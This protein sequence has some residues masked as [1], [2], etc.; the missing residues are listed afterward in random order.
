[1]KNFDS[2]WITAILLIKQGKYVEADLIAEQVIEF[3]KKGQGDRDV[4]KF[5]Y[6]LGREYYNATRYEKALKTTMRASEMDAVVHGIES[7]V[8]ASDMCLLAMIHEKL[9]HFSDAEPYYLRSLE[10]RQ[11]AFGD[12]HPETARTLYQIGCFY[13]NNLRLDKSR[14]FFQKAYAI[15]EKDDQ[16]DATLYLEL[17]SQL[18]ESSTAEGNVIGKE[19][20]LKESLNVHQKAFG[21]DHIGTAPILESLGQLF[22]EQGYIDLAERHFKKAFFIYGKTYGNDHPRAIDLQRTIRSLNS[23]REQKS[24]SSSTHQAKGYQTK[25]EIVPPHTITF[26]ESVQ[27]AYHGTVKCCRAV[28][29]FFRHWSRRKTYATLLILVSLAVLSTGLLFW[30]SNPVLEYAVRCDHPLVGRAALTLGANP[31]FSVDGTRSLLF[32]AVSNGNLAMARILVNAGANVNSCDNQ[33]RTPLFYATGKRNMEMVD[34]LLDAGGRIDQQDV[35]GQTPL[36]QA[37]KS[38]FSESFEK[39]SDE[40][41]D[42]NQEDRLKRSLLYHAIDANDLQSVEFLLARGVRPDQEND[43]PLNSRNLIHVAVAKGDPAVFERLLQNGLGFRGTFEDGTTILWPAADRGQEELIS[44]LLEK[45]IDVN[46][47]N[48]SGENIL[49]YVARKSDFDLQ[50]VDK[51]IRA[52][53]EVNHRNRSGKTVAFFL[54]NATI[55]QHLMKNGLDLSIADNDK[56]PPVL[57][58]LRKDDFARL[59][60]FK[61]M[62]I[63]INARIYEGHSALGWVLDAL[64]KEIAPI[65]AAIRKKAAERQS[66][67]DGRPNINQ[68]DP[69][70]PLQDALNGSTKRNPLDNLEALE[71][72]LKLMALMDT[73]EKSKLK[74]ELEL[75][76]VKKRIEERYAAKIKKLADIGANI[77]EKNDDGQTFLFQSVAQYQPSVTDVL[78]KCGADVEAPDNKGW[79]PLHQAATNTLR[80]ISYSETRRP[81]FTTGEIS[82]ASETIV[83]DFETVEKLLQAGA[84]IHKT[85]LSG[86]TPLH[87]AAISNVDTDVCKR[88]LENGANINAKGTRGWTPLHYA[89]FINPKTNVMKYLIAQG[90][91]IKAEDSNGKTPLDCAFTKEKKDILLE[92]LGENEKIDM[93]PHFSEEADPE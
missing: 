86:E 22:F 5:L 79:A 48:K 82:R 56:I 25:A 41:T 63:D 31:D 15:L 54:N 70:N 27:D 35:E 9:N 66:E 32:D 72:R 83:N 77:D 46:S 7:T 26:W 69:P 43:L 19:K 65:E 39:L 67:K 4:S 73:P 52:G 90:A 45:G 62:G 29:A 88:L 24:N 51:L 64:R 20:F 11:K 40:N 81:S 91:N 34:L 61:K 13:K 58:A 92:A 93:S 49:F 12:H 17:L 1:M 2:E 84:D 18:T 3:S 44:L 14:F 30:K 57:E 47:V 76:N 6:E 68:S 59:D 60:F 78:L 89:V 75:L 8:L 28:Y 33:Q 38:H 85:V 36:F 74:E 53:I 55:G 80:R 16:K 10:I 71:M 87:F 23:F 37:I 42:F 21:Q 50:S